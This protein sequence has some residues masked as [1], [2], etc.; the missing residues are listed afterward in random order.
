MRVAITREVSSGIARC[1][2]THM[3]REPIDIGRARAQHAE[4]QR[5]LA[6]LG[7]NV[8][9]LPEEPDLPDSVF[10]EDVAIV[11]PEIA[12]LTRP[13]AASRRSEVESI[14]AALAPH[15]RIERIDP[16]AT[17]DG[18]DVLVIGRT[19]LVGLSSRS[20]TRAVEQLQAIVA[21]WGYEVAPTPILGCLHLKSAVTRID[22]DCLLVNT[23]WVE[24]STLP[25]MRR[26]E[27][28][29]AESFAANALRVGTC[30]IH[31]AEF[32]R[33]R[34]RIEAEGIE[35]VPVDVSEL[36]KA[37]G[38]VTCCSLIFEAE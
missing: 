23:A 6:A 33:T 34:R 24:P 28:D 15:R 21:P 22:D 16:P 26:I 19:I 14:R 35:V 8:V 27:I 36:A 31:P 4:Y 37:E 1:E 12:I 32:A 3:E 38:G 13:G 17:L 18:G 20:D 5:A 29:P 9:C 2:L 25:A 11:L 30:V 10:V 7:C